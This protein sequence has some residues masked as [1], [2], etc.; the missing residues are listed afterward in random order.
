MPDTKSMGR[1]HHSTRITHETRFY[2][3]EEVHMEEIK[4]KIEDYVSDLLFRHDM[5]TWRNE[6]NQKTM[7]K[8]V[9]KCMEDLKRHGGLLEMLENNNQIEYF[10]R[11]TILYMV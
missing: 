8:I 9:E 10:V 1:C 7:D 4:K 11:Q 6:N 2:Q 3:K 5:A